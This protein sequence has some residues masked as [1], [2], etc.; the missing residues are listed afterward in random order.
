MVWREL[1]GSTKQNLRLHLQ[2]RS[3]FLHGNVIGTFTV[4]KVDDKL[5]SATGAYFKCA[6]RKFGLMLHIRRVEEAHTSLG[7]NI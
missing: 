5:C 6:D 4:T 2:G 3:L 1:C 7:S